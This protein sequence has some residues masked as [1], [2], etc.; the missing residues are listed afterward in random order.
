MRGRLARVAALSALLALLSGCVSVGEG[1]SSA[2]PW[3]EPQPWEGQVL[4]VPVQ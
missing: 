1:D 3:S 2:L 4:G